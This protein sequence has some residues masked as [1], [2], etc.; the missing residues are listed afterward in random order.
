M[1]AKK[2]PKADEAHKLYRD[3][4]K[5]VDIA[6]QLGVP[7]GTVR[8]WKSTYDWDAERSDKKS[9][10]SEK[11]GKKKANV[12]KECEQNCKLIDDGTKETLRNEDLT[13]EQQMFCIYYIKSFNATQSYIK[14]YGCS[15]NVANAEAYKMMV[16]PCVKAEIERLKEIK[17]QQIV[18]S[19]PDIVELQ[20]RIA[21]ADMGNYVSLK[22]IENAEGENLS[23]VEL[24]DSDR[25]DTQLIREVKEGKSGISIKLEDRQKAI[26][27]LTKYFIMNPMDKHRQEFDRQK[28]ELELLKLDMQTKTDGESEETAEDNF[29]EALNAAAKDVWSNE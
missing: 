11:K 23:S 2:N 20:M 26:D 18:I 9:E 12:R 8:R 3:G 19:E 13:P 21:F 6:N 25:T 10:R 5:L 4:M 27:W 28:V 29:L 22:T 16:K 14:A 24:K 15:Y 17:R 7:P 1:A